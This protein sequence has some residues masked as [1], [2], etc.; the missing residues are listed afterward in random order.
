MKLNIRKSSLVIASASALITMGTCDAGLFDLFRKDRKVEQ[1]VPDA[2]CSF[3]YNATTWQPWDTCHLTEPCQTGCNTDYDYSPPDGSIYSPNPESFNNQSEPVPNGNPMP[4]VDA[5]LVFPESPM[6]PI[7]V[8]KVRNPN[9]FQPATPRL[10]SQIPPPGQDAGLE[11]PGGITLP[12]PT[13]TPIPGVNRPHSG[14]GGLPQVPPEDTSVRFYQQPRQ[15][16]Q[17]VLQ[18]TA[19]WQQENN[20]M[21]RVMPGYYAQQQSVSNQARAAQQAAASRN[22][23]FLAPP[24]R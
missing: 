17:H 7:T 23:E 5:E 6:G 19:Y 10:P 8:P 16:Q 11:A 22:V 24:R 14:P 12:L 20:A 18:P 4:G 1:R 13:T 9:D 15:F 21:W 2:D 3:G